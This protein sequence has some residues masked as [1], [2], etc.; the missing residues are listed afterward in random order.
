MVT[1][2]ANFAHIAK[3]AKIATNFAHMEALRSWM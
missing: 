2:F 3:F 1:E